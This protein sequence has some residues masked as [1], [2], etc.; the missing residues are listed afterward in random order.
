MQRIVWL[1]ALL[2]TLSAC[3]Q[4][5]SEGGG[6]QTQEDA[7]RRIPMPGE[8]GGPPP[9]REDARAPDGDAEVP[10]DA[11][12]TTDSGRIRPLPQ[13]CAAVCDI[14]DDCGRTA[15]LWGGDRAACLAAC[16][17]GQASARFQSFLVCMQVTRCENLQECRVPP[18]PLPSCAAVCTAIDACEADFR[19][20]AGLPGDPECAAACASPSLEQRIVS[21][22]VP[23]VDAAG[24]A[25]D[26]PAFGRCVL[27][28]AAADCLRACDARAE[29]DESLDPIDCALACAREPVPEDPV[30]R[31][32]QQQARACLLSANDCDAVAQCER[33][34]LRPI[35]GEATVADLCAANAACPFF[36]AEA[37][38]EQ[39]EPLLRELAD[40]A[41]DCFTGHLRDHCGEPP[42]ACFQPAPALENA[43]EEHC[44]VSHLCGL[45]PAGQTEFACTEACH[46]AVRGGDPAAVEPYRRQFAC[47]YADSCAELTACQQQATPA[48]AC[49]EGCGRLAECGVEGADACPADCEARFDTA[50]V[51]GELACVQAAADCTGVQ[52]CRTPPPPGFCGEWCAALE[53][54]DL[55]D[56]RCPQRCDDA[57]FAGPDAFL[58]RVAC[59]TGTAR[60]DVRAACES[61]EVAP[62]DACLA[63]CRHQITCA[64]GEATAFEAC[65]I[66]CGGDVGGAEG[67]RFEAARGCLAEAGPA[68]ECAA[69]AACVDEAEPATACAA[70]CTELARC[71]I[72][73]DT[74]ACEAA[75]LAGGEALAARASCSLTA[76]RRGEGCGAVAACEGFEPEPA[77]PACV[78]LCGAQHTCDE[79]EDAFL[80]ERDCT[81]EPAGTPV[82]AA[83]AERGG[84][85]T[86]DQCLA[87]DGSIP[88]ACAE[89]CGVIA[90]CDG[91]VG[92][93]GA[94]FEDDDACAATCAGA[95]LVEGADYPPAL[96]ECVGQAG[97]GADAIRA[98]IERPETL[99]QESWDALVSCNLHELPDFLGGGGGDRGAYIQRCQQ[100]LMAN[101]A[102]RAAHECRI[103]AGA[104]AGGDLIACFLEFSQC[105]PL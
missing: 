5:S 51:R 54:C 38:A 98:C 66:A 42:Y 72:D 41:V 17:D 99:C 11:E 40:G 1:L 101:P 78:T 95:A 31:R 53:G 47:A 69:L 10:A 28:S 46:A 74:P 13:D 93:G 36:D 48:V 81:P 65:A 32:R 61:G 59:V 56:A 87:A 18:R 100:A 37:C 70:Y 105:P 76:R 35:V 60:C 19:V 23:V 91:L 73:A 57:D 94:L 34:E 90:A 77:S 39:V 14:F 58:A 89:T 102:T 92:E 82:R 15:D 3:E 83:C 86:L 71:R 104:A 12:V 103:R 96:R 63:W 21:C 79:D 44:H 97:C 22:G 8:D 7:S 9:D 6:Q 4:D 29:C 75:C 24:G 30:A 33:R 26:E 50:R 16:A 20:P 64:D 67:L 2:V 62:A 80:C 85:E 88:A 84:C 43:C 68:A 25:C 27:E 55:T 49:A 45:L 52:L